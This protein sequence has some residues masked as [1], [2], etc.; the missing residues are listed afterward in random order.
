[1]ATYT[2]LSLLQRSRQSDHS[3][4]LD[5]QSASYI[6]H[7]SIR[8][9]TCY[10]GCTRRRMAQMNSLTQRLTHV[11]SPLICSK[12]PREDIRKRTSTRTPNAIVDLDTTYILSKLE[13][14]PR[15]PTPRPHSF[16]FRFS[17]TPSYHPS[18]SHSSTST[19]APTPSDMDVD[20]EVD[21]DDSGTAGKRGC[22]E[23]INYNTEEME[24]GGLRQKRW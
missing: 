5:P 6:H 4:R 18:N 13:F 12:T 15:Y 9:L 8:I 24:D 20:V 3:Q 10:T 19:S 17:P 16:H 2:D 14:I 1:M 21:V 11:S 23:A 22:S 7:P